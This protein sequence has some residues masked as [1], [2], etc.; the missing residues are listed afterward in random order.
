MDI[1][2][3]DALT[4]RFAETHSRR[5]V[6]LFAGSLV[7]GGLH[8]LLETATSEA[9]GKNTHKRRKRRKRKTRRT[10]STEQS[11]APA[12]PAPDPCDG[13]PEW[14]P[15][16]AGL[17]CQGGACSSGA[18]S[19]AEGT[20]ACTADCPNNDCSC[21]PPPCACFLTLTGVTRC[22]INKGCGNC[23]RD[24]DCVAEHGL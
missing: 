4:R 24:E 11:P 20:D 15:C 23:T 8:G 13:L 16:G 14:T 2:R 1:T 3:F 5:G 17:F 18:G 19:C 10:Q 12:P 21:G 22:G 6:G 7:L 9:K